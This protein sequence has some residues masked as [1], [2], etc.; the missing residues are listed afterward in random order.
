MSERCEQTSERRSEWPST[1]RGDFIILQPNVQGAIKGDQV[2]E[3][4][5]AEITAWIDEGV[6][7]KAFD[8]SKDDP[9]IIAGDLNTNFRGNAAGELMQLK[10]HLMR[11]E[12]HLMRLKEQFKAC[13]PSLRPGF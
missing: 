4:Q 13:G 2:R 7:T 9:V 10:V 11:L 12:E 3:K 6:K 1:L 5:A 8:I